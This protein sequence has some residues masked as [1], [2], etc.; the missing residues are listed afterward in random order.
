MRTY[1]HMDWEKVAG[2]VYSDYDHPFDILGPHIQPHSIKITCFLPDAKEVY[3]KNKRTGRLTEMTLVDEAGMFSVVFKGKTIP[4]Y[5][6]VAKYSDGTEYETEDA[7]A[8]RPML[9]EGELDLFSKGENYDIYRI[10][11]AHFIKIAGTPGVLFAVWAPN[12]RRVSVVGDFNLWDG[13]RNIMEFDEKHGIHYLFVPNLKEGMFYKYEVKD[14]N[15]GIVLKADP[16]ATYAEKRPDNASILYESGY[17]WKDSA[18]LEKREA[19]SPLEGPM[20]VYEV[21]LG[22]WRKPEGPDDFWN[23]REIAK[24]LAKYAKDMG[25]THVELLPVMEHPFDGSWGYQVTGYYAPTARYGTPDDFK[26]FVDH[27]HKNGIGVIL[28]WVPAHFPKDS[29]GLGRFDGTCLYEHLDPRK[30]EHPHWGTLIFNYA[31]PEVS[32]FLISNALYWAEEFHIDGIRMDAVASM[33][34]LDYGRGEGGWIPNESGGN[35]NLEAIDFLRKVNTAM[36][37]R[38][39]NV[40]MIA[41]E[42]TAWPK[43]T[44]PV[45]DGGLGFDLKWNMGL[46]NDFLSYMRT[47]HIFRRD[48]H[49]NITFGLTYAFS[50][51][52]MCI[53]SHDE[54]VHLKCSMLNKMPGNETQKFANLRLAYTFLMGHP[55][56]K[57]LFMGQEF[58][59][60]SEWNEAKT[61]EWKLIK[62]YDSHKKMLEFTKALNHFYKEHPAAYEDDFTEKG[63]RWI[64]CDDFNRSTLSFVRYGRDEHDFLLYVYNFTPACYENFKQ[65]VLLP[66]RYK[67]VFN[68]DSEEFGGTGRI[69]KRIHTSKKSEKEDTE[70]INI[71]LAPLSAGIWMYAGNH[72]NA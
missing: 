64:S 15:G 46:E 29:F 51:K 41:E 32:D 55:G 26:F 34:Y 36:K 30:G 48:V 42:S 21:H 20:N 4:K 27:M 8:Y 60:R 7:Y 58:G 49:G 37:E 62:E 57:L 59:Q 61:L 22:S 68:T 6:Y 18:F 10:L 39:K 53:I 1:I 3:L 65:N 19:A 50:E 70:F 13:R 52:F 69:N 67:E 9:D 44:A 66:G 14:R 33:L 63:F 38:H 31:R 40:L 12:A 47:D 11:G 25:Y 23:Y 24:D 28:D 72:E 56:K 2:I 45:T 54:V 43:I 71:T 5:T 35:E 16:Y 17:K